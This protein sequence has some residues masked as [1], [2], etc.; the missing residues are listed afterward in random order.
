MA[1]CHRGWMN[2]DDMDSMEKA[3]GMDAPKVTRMRVVN[4][5]AVIDKGESG[6]I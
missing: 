5:C 3:A 2:N 1:F 6:W 4:V